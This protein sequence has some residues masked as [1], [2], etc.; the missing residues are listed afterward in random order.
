MTF[1]INKENMTNVLGEE[2]TITIKDLAGNSIAVISKE[3]QVNENGDYVFDFTSKVSKVILETSKPVAEGNLIISNVK[4]S[5]NSMYSKDEYKMFNELITKTVGKAKYTY[6]EN[7]V[8][9][10]RT[11]IKTALNNVTTKATLVMDRDSLSTLASNENVE[12]RLELNNNTDLSDIYGHSV[13]EIKLPKYVQNV[14]VTDSSIMYG[15]GLTISNVEVYDLDGDKYI[16]VTLDGTQ[17]SISTGVL[18]NGTNIVL[19][20]NIKVDLYAPATESEF[21]LKYSNDAATN[22][23]ENGVS[24]LPVSYSAPT[25]LVAV[26]STSNFDS[27]GSVLTSVK[28]GEK[29]A[30]IAKNDVAK[31]AK[32][33]IIVMNNNSNIV[34]DLNILGRIPF[35]GVKDILTDEE[36]GTTLDTKLI[37]GLV[38]DEKNSTSFTIYYSENG[39]ATKDL[40]NVSNAWTV[41]PESFD[42]IKS[43]LIVPNDENYEMQIAEVLRFTYDYEIPADLK[44]NESIYGTFLA[45]YT[46]HTDVATV[47]EKTVADK[48]G[49]TTGEGPELSVKLSSDVK[50]SIKEYEEMTYKVEVKNSGKTS[51]QNVVVTLPVDS[52]LVVEELVNEEGITANT[53]DGRIEFIIPTLGIDEM[54]ELNFKLSARAAE[55]DTPL[56]SSSIETSK[57]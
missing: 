19:N 52:A 5:K 16:R 11:E 36:L 25:G 35:A 48:I 9:L 47:D 26:N 54:K 55:E 28:Q 2:G 41:A 21:V 8:E 15:E 1:V 13:F 37:A 27:V 29:E 40:G 17:N 23:S 20:T 6:V 7:L 32:M 42:N 12:L 43:Y 45:Y 38:S 39:E 3:F 44:L 22:Y 18:N 24:I 34:S 30:E 46:N 57:K 14:E 31:I 53:I 56:I 10:G 33:E 49:L 50:T 4:V 51:A